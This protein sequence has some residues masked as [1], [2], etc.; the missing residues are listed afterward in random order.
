MLQLCFAPPAFEAVFNTQSPFNVCGVIFL[1]VVGFIIN[2]WLWRKQRQWKEI[3]YECVCV[4]VCVSKPA[5][6][7]LKQQTGQ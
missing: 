5:C 1:W 2:N 6:F 7:F 4:C 3:S